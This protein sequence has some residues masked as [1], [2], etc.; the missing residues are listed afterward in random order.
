MDKDGQIASEDRLWAEDK[1]TICSGAEGR[2]FGGRVR[3]KDKVW[4]ANFGR[5]GTRCGS[6]EEPRR[7]LRCG[8]GASK[9][10]EQMRLMLKSEGS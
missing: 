9:Q 10:T 4:A 1:T 7:G 5:A 8:R 3:P 6:V 2:R